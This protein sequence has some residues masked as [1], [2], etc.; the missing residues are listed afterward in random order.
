MEH[1]YVSDNCIRYFIL[2]FGVNMCKPFIMPPG[3]LNHYLTGF[4]KIAILEK[5]YRFWEV[6][7]YEIFLTLLLNNFFKR[8]GGMQYFLKCLGWYKLFLDLVISP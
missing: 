7:M 4:W 3:K 6:G 8:G 1:L 2:N 5:Y